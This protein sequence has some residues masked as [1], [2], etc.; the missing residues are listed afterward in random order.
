MS[1]KTTLSLEI[2]FLSFAFYCILRSIVLIANPLKYMRM[3]QKQM[4]NN[5]NNEI[6]KQETDGDGKRK[7][8]LQLSLMSSIN[9]L[10][11][12]EFEDCD[13]PGARRTNK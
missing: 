6:E 2:S 1:Y 9:A 11:T 3:P 7:E 12:Q 5:N 10:N 4:I 13:K 8:V